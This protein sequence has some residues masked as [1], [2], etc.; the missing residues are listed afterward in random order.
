MRKYVMILDLLLLFTCVALL[1]IDL[2]IKNDLI[3]RAKSLEEKLDEQGRSQGG[4]DIHLAV[5]RDIPPGDVFLD[6]TMEAKSSSANGTSPNRPRKRNVSAANRG[7]GDTD[8]RV[9]QPG[10]QVGP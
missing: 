7:S 9:Q 6:S 4:N 3:T 1:I 10:D 5:P 8:S 2:Q